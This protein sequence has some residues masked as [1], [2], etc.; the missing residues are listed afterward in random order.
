MDDLE[1]IKLRKIAET[2]SDYLMGLENQEFAEEFGGV[3]QLKKE[4]ATAVAEYE[5]D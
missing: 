2:A 1:E 3:E 5:E 4:L